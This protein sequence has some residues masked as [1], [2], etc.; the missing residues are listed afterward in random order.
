MF[1]SQLGLPVLDLVAVLIFFACW[2][3]YGLVVDGRKGLG[4]KGLVN[5]THFYRKLWA[6]EMVKRSNRVADTALIGNL[7]NSVSFYANTTIYI[8]AGLFAVLGTMDQLVDITA[9]LPFNKNVSRSS[10]E[11][12]VLLVL[13]VFVVAYFKFTWSLRQFNLLS[14][15]VGAAPDGHRNTLY[16]KNYV[17]RMAQINSLAGDEFNRGIRAYYFAIASTSWMVN[18]V[19]FIA[20]SLLIVFVLI[21]RDFYSQALTILAQGQELDFAAHEEAPPHAAAHAGPQSE[22]HLDQKK[23]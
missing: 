8:M 14:I 4:R 6:T 22:G 1:P 17:S 16:V 19:L 10:L 15:L 12:K 7:V 3:G 11:L 13:T 23:N 9:D 2:S 5:R 20:V 18:P 21:R